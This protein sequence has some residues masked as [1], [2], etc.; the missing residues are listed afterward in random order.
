MFLLFLFNWW[1]WCKLNHCI[2]Y[3]NYTIIYYFVYVTYSFIVHDKKIILFI[4]TYL[5]ALQ[6]YIAAEMSS[7]WHT[8][9]SAFFYFFLTFCLVTLVSILNMSQMLKHMHQ[10]GI[11]NFATFLNVKKIST[12]LFASSQTAFCLLGFCGGNNSGNKM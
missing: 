3:G 5:P 2:L 12:I 8:H 6:I 1:R 9:N 10:M 7:H 11:V 4:S